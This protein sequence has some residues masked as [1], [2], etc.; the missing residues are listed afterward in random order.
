MGADATDEME[1]V[2]PNSQSQQ[3]SEQNQRMAAWQWDDGGR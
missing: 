2:V 3:W 1:C